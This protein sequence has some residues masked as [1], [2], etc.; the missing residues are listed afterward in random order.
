MPKMGRSVGNMSAENRKMKDALA[1]AESGETDRTSRFSVEYLTS[2]KG[3]AN[4]VANHVISGGADPDALKSFMPASLTC[5]NKFLP[6]VILDKGPDVAEALGDTPNVAQ[7]VVMEL[8]RMRSDAP[9]GLHTMAFAAGFMIIIGSVLNLFAHIMSISPLHAFFSIM[10]FV[11]GITI[12]ALEQQR[13]VF[14][15]SVRAKIEQYFLFLTLITGRGAFLMYVGSIQ[16][17]V[18]WKK[19]GLN[20]IIGLYVVFVGGTYIHTGYSVTNKLK[21]LTHSL[22]SPEVIKKAFQQVDVDNNGTLDPKELVELMK[23][24]GSTMNVKEAETAVMLLDK[25]SDGGVSLEE[26]LMFMER[27]DDNHMF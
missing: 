27:P 24:L 17:A 10:M 25:D 23:L 5:L 3:D 21:Q 2:S 4:E 1:K 11:F 9:D 19:S 13:A 20:V 22:Q 7:S 6:S 14:P 26:F 12:M 18:N 8:G 15:P 16:A